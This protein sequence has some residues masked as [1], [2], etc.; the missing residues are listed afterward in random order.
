MVP[1]SHGEGPPRVAQQALRVTFLI[2]SDT[3]STRDSIEAICALPHIKPVAV[4]M[5]T[6]RAPLSRRLRNL[7][8]NISKEGWGYPLRRTLGALRN[9]TER[10]AYRTAVSEDDVQ[11]LLRRAFPQRFFSI[12][13]L[14]NYYGFAVHAVGSL[15]SA[16]AVEHLL[17]S[18]AD[19]GIVLGTRIL[20][21]TTYNVPRLGCLNLHKGKV[22]LYRGM[23]PGFW[24]L[25]DGATTAG[26]TVHF[27]DSGLDTGD[28]L[29][30]REIPISP[31]ETPDSLLEK[32]HKEGNVAI[33]EAVS[34]VHAGS[35]VRRP[36]LPTTNKPRS[37]PS[38][39][40]VLALR[41]RLLHWRSS[42]DIYGIIKNLYALALYY[43]GV[44]GIVRAVHRFSSARGAIFLYHRINDYAG[45][46]LTADT[47][48][49][50]AQLITL[51]K[52]YPT[53]ASC[54]LVR[55]IREKLPI[56]P[57]TVIIHFDDCYEDV[58]TNGGPLLTALGISATAFVNSGFVDTCR[59][60]PHDAEEYP[61]VFPNLSSKEVREWAQLGFEVGNHTVN[62]VDLGVHPLDE[63]KH[64]IRDC[65]R[66]LQ[67]ITGGR[68]INLFSFPFG[69]VKN[70]RPEV[71]DC[72]RTSGYLGL[73]SAHGG[74][75]TSGTDL[76]DIPR[77]GANGDLNPLV[78]LLEVEDLAPHQVADH[79]RRI[80][81]GIPRLFEFK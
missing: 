24:E 36:Q 23:P 80:T 44:Y 35:A 37:K 71:V 6:D 29:V 47:Q 66:Y 78:L 19:L 42:S 55:R 75:V 31:K 57:T 32:L 76:Y 64:E 30:E 20:K 54:E 45:D 43:L 65:E 38:H 62:H 16:I 70:I 7:R 79:F 49:F 13:Q 22:P 1:E 58:F 50:A 25:F 68:P 53:M 60:Y 52:R 28:V 21:A 61:F 40:D 9:F 18:K 56:P 4:L 77:L 17:A 10:L 33:C 48:T 69:N 74:F 34:R 14:G 63:A 5:D 2:G 3:Q 8:R 26:V 27:V 67:S 72:I 41:T 11:N 39:K 12:S 59:V 73:F 81:R 46:P 15:N 51:S